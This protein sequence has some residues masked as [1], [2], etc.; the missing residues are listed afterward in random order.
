MNC[1][2]VYFASDW[3]G[4]PTGSYKDG[5]SYNDFGVYVNKYS[6]AEWGV[7][8]KTQIL[9]TTIGKTYTCKVSATFNSDMT[10]T[11]TFKDEG[12]QTTKKYTLVNGTNNFE[13]DS[14]R[15]QIIRKYL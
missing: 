8:M 13:I 11:I 9:S 5:G 6:G 14:H 1:W 3:G 10:D 12:T 15:Q 7:Q 2:S 4:N